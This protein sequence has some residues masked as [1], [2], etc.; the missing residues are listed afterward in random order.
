S[1]IGNV[2]AAQLDLFTRPLQSEAIVVQRVQQNADTSTTRLTLH[3]PL[4]Y[5]YDRTTT[6]V[7]GNVVEVTQGSTVVDEVLGSGDGQ[8]PFLQFLVK[9]APL[10]WLEQADGSIAPQLWISVNGVPWQRVETLCDCGPDARAYQLTQDAQG[11]ARIQFGDGAHGLRPP[12]GQNNITATYRVGAGASGNVPA[13]SLTRPP[14]GVAGIKSVLNPV[15]ATGGINPPLRS[16]L[17]RQVPIAVCD[18]GRIVT[19]E[20]MQTF[21]LNRPEVGAAT[22]NTVPAAENVA[23]TAKTL[24]TL[25]G[26]QNSVPDMASPTFFSLTTAFRTALASGSALPCDLL[27]YQPL[28]FKVIG[29]FTANTGADPHKVEDEITAL[30]QAI[31][32]IKAMH[33]QEAVRAADICAEIRKSVPGIETVTVTKLWAPTRKPKPPIDPKEVSVA[34]PMRPMVLSPC[35]ACPSNG[36]QILCLS[37]D[38]DAVTFTPGSAQ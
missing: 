12:T 15:A 13:G 37:M 17:R 28:P 5:L 25:A 18:L 26:L 4:R 1:T 29:T 34:K 8:K 31:Y 11:R 3:Q 33:F 6:S 27:P 20:D 19:E 32:D 24:I 36:A 14:I 30:L 9:Q 38:S 10:T 2:T 35:G 16:D 23:P 22:L 7:Y 21:V